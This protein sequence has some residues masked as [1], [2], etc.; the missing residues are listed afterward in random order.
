L[1]GFIGKS[2]HD[3]FLGWN[4]GCH[5]DTRLAC[6]KVAVSILREKMD[7]QN[8]PLREWAVDVLNA[9]SKVPLSQAAQLAL[10]SG[11][12]NLPSYILDSSGRQI[13]DSSGRAITAD[14]A[15]ITADSA[16]IVLGQSTNK[17]TNVPAA[18]PS[19]K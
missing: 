17:T 6:S 15:V 2:G 12:L 8:Q 1:A 16:N 18:Q 14:T 19:P 11:K 10:K 4:S 5:N 7:D 13:L 3:H 9:E